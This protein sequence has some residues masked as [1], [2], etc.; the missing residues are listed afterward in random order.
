MNHDP[1]LQG[2]FDQQLATLGQH[3]LFE[4]AERI[5]TDKIRASVTLDQDAAP[6][7]IHIDIFFKDHRGRQDQLHPLSISTHPD[8]L[9][10]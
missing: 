7:E 10:P 8:I 9:R 4:R 6:F 2:G 3:L 1:T 5:L